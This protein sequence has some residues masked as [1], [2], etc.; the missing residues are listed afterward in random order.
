MLLILIRSYNISYLISVFVCNIFKSACPKKRGFKYYLIS[1]P[2]HII[3]IICNSV[4]IIYRIHYIGCYMMLYKS[5]PNLCYFTC[6]YIGTHIK[7]R[8]LSI[9]HPCAFPWIHCP[10][11]A[12]FFGFYSCTVKIMISVFQ[13]CPCNFR[14]CICKIRKYKKLGIPER[15]SLISL[16]AQ[17]FCT[18]S[19][20]IIIRFYHDP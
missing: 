9:I 5:G 7:R 12:V 15:M 17:S 6:Y 20:S 13:K 14:M 1:V 18:Y 8:Y 4:I 3:I 10:F 16:T 11:I 19:N 2:F